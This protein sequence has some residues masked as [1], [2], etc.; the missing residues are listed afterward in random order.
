MIAIDI[1]Y[2]VYP[3]PERKLPS[4]DEIQRVIH[5]ADSLICEVCTILGID[6][7]DLK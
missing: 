1:H 2:G 4:E 5:F 7:E 3:T 6:L